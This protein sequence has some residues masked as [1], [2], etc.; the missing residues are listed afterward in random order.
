[1]EKKITFDKEKIWSAIEKDQK[2][3]RKNRVIPFLLF[4]CAM[5]LTILI[6]NFYLSSKNASEGNVLLSYSETPNLDHDQ[7]ANNQ[8]TVATLNLKSAQQKAISLNTNSQPTISEEALS[9]ISDISLSSDSFQSTTDTDNSHQSPSQ[10]LRPAEY[11]LLD[12]AKSQKKIILHPQS[13][14]SLT[15]ATLGSLANNNRIPLNTSLE[16]NP[17]KLDKKRFHVANKSFFVNN[18]SFLT[19]SAN[20]DEQL[21]SKWRESQTHNYSNT[22][23][24]GLEIRFASNFTIAAGLEI[25]VN[26]FTY[27]QTTITEEEIVLESDTVIIYNN[28]IKLGDRFATTTTTRRLVKNNEFYKIGIPVSIGYRWSIN[29][30]VAIKS[31]LESKLNFWQNYNGIINDELGNPI[32]DASQQSAYFTRNISLRLSGSVQI[33]K[34]VTKHLNVKFGIKYTPG[35]PLLN[36]ATPLHPY[37]SGIGISAGLSYDF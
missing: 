32:F 30:S 11:P 27:R 6:Y 14:Q 24:L 23:N 25:V 26:S 22:T 33:E 36:E 19:A 9:S 5:T 34:A 35:S 29:R 1:M 13:I 15:P 37:H 21:L 10:L 16:L 4:A 20:G 8:T 31:L 3:K 17:S 12:I 18:S 7:T 28:F 2:Q